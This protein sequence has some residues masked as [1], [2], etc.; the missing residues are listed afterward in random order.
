MAPE[1]VRVERQDL[2]E[3]GNN[4][5]GNKP[6]FE[7]AARYLPGGLIAERWVYRSEGTLSV[8]EEYEYADQRFFQMR[9]FDGRGQET[10]VQ[11][12][13]LLDDRT[14]ELLVLSPEGKNFLALFLRWTRTGK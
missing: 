10:Q 8:R 5:G 1:F 2:R 12:K 11:T 6:Y 4:S 13:R 14:S 3:E 7:M 9:G